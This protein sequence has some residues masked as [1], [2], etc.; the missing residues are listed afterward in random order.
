MSKKDKKGFLSDE[1]LQAV[2][3]MIPKLENLVKAHKEIAEQ[4]QLYRQSGGNEIPGIEKHLAL[5]E[6]TCEVCKKTT[7]AEKATRTK[8]PEVETTKAKKTKKKDK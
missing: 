6:Q 1:D 5:K 4:Y 7:K 2:I 8:V 3:A